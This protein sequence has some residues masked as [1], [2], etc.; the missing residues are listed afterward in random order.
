MRFKSKQNKVVLKDGIVVKTLQS[1]EALQREIEVLKKLKAAGLAVPAVVGAQG[2]SLRLE[3][4]KGPTYEALAEKMTAKQAAALGAWLRGYHKATGALRGDVNLRNFIWHKETCVGLD[5]DE[6][7][8]FGGPE[9]DQGK[10]IAFTATYDPPFTF[11][12]EKS[13]GLL[14]QAFLQRG[15]GRAEIKKQYLLEIA[16]VKERRPNANFKLAE[17]AVFFEKLN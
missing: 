2:N 10:I 1:Q 6:P 8:T 15:G 12:K 9:V 11:G 16:A 3:Y 14:L 7:L 5:F 13:C 4:I 17:A